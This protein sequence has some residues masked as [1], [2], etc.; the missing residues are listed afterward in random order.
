MVLKDLR[1][2]SRRDIIVPHIRPIGPAPVGGVLALRSLNG[3][4]DATDTLLA[5]AAVEVLAGCR[6]LLAIWEHIADLD[7]GD[8]DVSLAC[9]MQARTGTI[10]GRRAIAAD[11]KK[12]MRSAKGIPALP[13]LIS[14]LD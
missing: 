11:G 12:T 4:I 8:L 14:A 2:G 9:W 1:P 6:T 5:L 7:S 13:H 3:G 10:D